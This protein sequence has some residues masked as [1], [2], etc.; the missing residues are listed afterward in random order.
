MKL[1]YVKEA[2]G[3]EHYISPRQVIEIKVTHSEYNGDWCIVINLVENRVYT[4]NCKS[5]NEYK[6]RLYEINEAMEC[7]N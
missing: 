3:T 5:E 6:T 2:D 1:I 4:I 7:I